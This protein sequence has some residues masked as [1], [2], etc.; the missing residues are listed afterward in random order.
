M[1]RY[2]RRWNLRLHG[3]AETE[4]E[5]VLEE[6]MRVCREILPNEK[7]RLQIFIDDAHRVGRKFTGSSRPRSII[8]RF[9]AR[10]YRDYIW[11]GAKG[12]DFLK[13]NGLRFTE[14]LCKEDRESR[15]KLWPS[16]QKAREEGKS[17]YFVGGR[18]FINGV[19]IPAVFTPMQE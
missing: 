18:G 2:G 8:I 1:E 6:V 10:R 14:D 15:Q 12:N 4:K 19:E 3:V 11:K 16:I 7:E 13:K 17:A 9:I 5:N